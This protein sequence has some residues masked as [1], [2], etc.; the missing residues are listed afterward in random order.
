MAGGANFGRCPERITRIGTS[1]PLA[2]TG[3]P[4]HRVGRAGQNATRQLE[5]A[6][7]QPNGIFVLKCALV[8]HWPAAN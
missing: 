5:R 3:P 2:K 7:T 4:T 1:S 6:G 8:N